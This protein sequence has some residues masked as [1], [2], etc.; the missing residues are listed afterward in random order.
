M[1][2]KVCILAAG[3]GSRMAPLTDKINKSLLP[4]NFKATI[5]HIIEKFDLNTEIIIAVGHLKNSILD[6]LACA[7]SN[8]KFTIVEVENYS[9]EGSGPG[10]SLMQC[11]KYLDEPFIFFASDTLVLEDIPL[12]N[13]NWLGVSKVDQTIDY[14]TVEIK[15]NKIK[16]LIDKTDNEHKNAFIGLAGIYDYET[17]FKSLEANNQIKAGEYQV[18]NGFSGLINKSLYPEYFTWCDTGNINGYKN[19]NVVMSKT[20]SDFDFSKNAEFLY[21]IDNKVIKY[22]ENEEIAENRY[23]RSLSLKG[24]C[25]KI[26]L[27]KK[28]FYCYE[29]I[30]G[31]VIYDVINNDVLEDLL[32][33][34]QKKLWTE[35]NC[36][37][38]DLKNFQSAC[39]D[40]YY[41]KTNSRINKYFDKYSISDEKSTINGVNVPSIKDMFK[42]IDW[43][44]LSNGI[45]SNFHGDL[46]FDNILKKENGEFL[47]I[48]W[49]QDFGGFIDYGDRYYDFAKLNGGMQVSYKLIKK[50][51]FSYSKDS[52][53]RINID[54]KIP[55]EL[56][57]SKKS[58][59]KF[60]DTK[61]IDV[62]KVNILTSIIYLNMSPMHNEPFDHF[63]F[64]LGKLNLFRSLFDKYHL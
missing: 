8:R 15:D 39:N 6:Y 25:P 56:I 1:K 18:S 37:D 29:K 10:L 19:A 3:I 12:P 49:R 48:D 40:F 61:N 13:K 64:N 35:V 62:K 55:N 59:L 22:F 63:I 46:Q 34:L 58:F 2:Y 4:V 53:G 51:N 60:L 11:K 36:E 42:V 50:D 30:K 41:N 47:L 5:S 28:N 27:K 43:D 20:Q 45:P 26:I 57:V 32:D 23:L 52:I 7:H 16:K 31:N 21:F 54:H 14:C 44:N 24:L 9:G 17:F 33:W 38:L